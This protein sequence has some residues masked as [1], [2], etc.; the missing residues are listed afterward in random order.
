M[1]T[2]NSTVGPQLLPD[3]RCAGAPKQP[4][5]A[6]QNAADAQLTD[7]QI[8]DSRQRHVALHS[9]SVARYPIPCE[10]R[11]WKIRPHVFQVWGG[12]CMKRAEEPRE[13]ETSKPGSTAR[14]G[15]SYTVNIAPPD[16][17]PI[18]EA[19]PPGLGQTD[20]LYRI[21]MRPRGSL[22]RSGAP[23]SREAARKASRSWPS[24]PTCQRRP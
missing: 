3:I 1:T 23:S 18:S 2:A 16:G 5:R 12:C 8:P 14:Y 22:Q 21:D 13:A 19:K 17:Q 6:L 10:Y 4:G 20:L 7:H 11:P 24:N 9:F 15:R